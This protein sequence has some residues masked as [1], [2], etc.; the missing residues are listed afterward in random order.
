MLF[1]FLSCTF[2]AQVLDTNIVLS[3]VKITANKEIFL[4][5]SKLEKLDTL[6]LKSIS[7]GSLNDAIKNYLPIYV[8]S[9]AGGLSTIRFRGTSAEHTAILF[10]GININSLTLGQSNI[11]SIPLFIF[12]K[13]KIQYGSSASL[14]GSDAIGGSIQLE[15]TPR[16][17]KGISLGLEQYF[18]SFGSLF[19]GV[20]AG[21]S[22]K[23]RI[24]HLKIYRNLI[25][26]DF[27][28]INT[29]VKDFDSNKFVKDTTKNSS[30]KS[31][32]FLEEMYYKYSDKLFFYSKI[33]YD[34][35]CRQIQPN[36]SANY[37]GGDNA[38]IE[39][40]HL[41]AISGFKYYKGMG[42]FTMDFGY[43]YDYQKY[44]QN[45]NQIISTTSFITNLNYY[46]TK[47][48]GGILNIGMLYKYIKPDVY[49]YKNDIKEDRID[50]FG[51]YKKMVI[52]GFEAIINLRESI[53]VDYKK[54]H[55]PSVGLNYVMNLNKS[56]KLILKTS[57]SKS[58]KIPTFNQRFWYPN[59]NTNILP[60][61]GFNYEFGA[62]L[63]SKFVF[64]NFN[65]SINAYQMIVD[66]W[67]Q[68][69]NLDTWRPVNLKQVKNSGIEIS[70]NTKW[71]INKFDYQT[72]FNYSFTRAKE[73]KS[74]QN[75]NSSI[76]KQ[77]IYTPVNIAKF[78]SSIKFESWII[79]TNIAYTGDRYTETYKV[80]NRY[81]LWN[82]HLDKNILMSNHA[83]NIGVSINN[84]LNKT[85]QN[86]E[87]YAMP[88]RNF[89]FNL[90]YNFNEEE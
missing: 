54:N 59:G 55:A 30:Q 10:N 84:I 31:F 24:F 86:W 44:N 53:V 70:L 29:A 48:W 77:L 65:F 42:K 28:F 61:T 76:G 11:S 60:E 16:W 22:D 58:Y 43:V 19:S 50:V 27:P 1:I 69:I 63:L 32:G 13:L 36:M 46:Y 7:S 62:N 82:I 25:D 75:I 49:A 64:G 83:I 2:W 14:Y 34:N 8:K 41:R 57:V 38:K 37:Y 85:Y 39:N 26:N 18:G 6:Q 4:V 5:G 74:Y 80:L 90:K 23:K 71:S 21:Y 17:D 40:K 72:G 89:K 87:Y 45:K 20:K 73:V 3:P 12:D 51:S 68:W 33:W 81:W 88:G 79:Q 47:L 67:I 9:N 15:N 56:R 52:P 66:N 35:N 78:F